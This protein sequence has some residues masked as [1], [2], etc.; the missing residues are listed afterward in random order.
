MDDYEYSRY[1]LLSYYERKILW[2]NKNFRSEELTFDQ[3]IKELENV[4][5]NSKKEPEI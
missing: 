3:V 5:K 4:I 2:V 1:D